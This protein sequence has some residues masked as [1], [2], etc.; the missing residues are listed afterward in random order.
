MP[1]FR[2]IRPD[3]TIIE[4]E[5]TELQNLRRELQAIDNLVAEADHI[6]LE[7]ANNTSISKRAGLEEQLVPRLHRIL[8]L[9]SHSTGISKQVLVDEIE[10]VKVEKATSERP[11]VTVSPHP[12]RAVQRGTFVDQRI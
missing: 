1:V 10:R 8:E 9:I 3:T 4:A 11:S 12:L 5:L 2:L 7:I 6:L